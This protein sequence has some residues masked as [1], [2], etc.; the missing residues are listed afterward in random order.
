MSTTISKKVKIP[1]KERFRE[2]ML[3]GIKC[4]TSRTK[5]YG[6]IADT[7]EVFG[8]TFVITEISK[9]KL[10]AV[11]DRYLV[12]GC[13]SRED[14]IELWQKLHPRTGFNPEQLVFVHVFAM[15]AKKEA[16]P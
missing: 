12:E 11:G 6:N 16:D 4:W 15:H 2:P 8:E 5:R 1:F 7:F 9:M 14:F 10:K 3:R 13:E